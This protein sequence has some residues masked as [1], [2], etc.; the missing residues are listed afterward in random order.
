VSHGVD[1]GVGCVCVLW[2]VVESGFAYPLA[3]AC[4]MEM[5]KVFT[6]GTYFPPYHYN[7]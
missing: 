7:V 4:I 1:E 3:R 5:L 2:G 6:E